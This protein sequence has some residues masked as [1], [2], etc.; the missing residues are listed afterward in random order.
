MSIDKKQS[1]LNLQ[2]LLKSAIRSLQDTYNKYRVAIIEDFRYSWYSDNG[3][4]TVLGG[5]EERKKNIEYLRN[6]V[7]SLKIKVDAIKNEIKEKEESEG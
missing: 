2:I 7:M 6:E 1:E 4:F 5:A 3:E